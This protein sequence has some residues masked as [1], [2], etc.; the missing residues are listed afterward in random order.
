MIQEIFWYLSGR[1]E[2]EKIGADNAQIDEFDDKT[3][4]KDINLK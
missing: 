2:F 1:G 4:S 3:L